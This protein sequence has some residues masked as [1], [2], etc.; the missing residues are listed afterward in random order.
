MLPYAAGGGKPNDSPHETRPELDST[1]SDRLRTLRVLIAHDWII[2]WA[3][4]ERC[5]EQMFQLFPQADLVVGLLTPSLRTYN[6]VTRRAT[7]TWL[8]RVPFARRHHRWFLPLEALAFASLD[9][10]AYD[11]VVSSS[12]AFSKM[13][14]VD[15]PARHICY[16]HS[17]PRYLWDLHQVYLRRSGM[18][19][20]LGLLALGG[21]LR[22][23]DHRAG[24][25]VDR[26][27]AN[28]HFVRERIR[29]NYG[30]D[31]H[32]LY[33]PVARKP[34]QGGRC[35]REDFVLSL[36]R[37]VE[38]KR[39]DLAIAAANRLGVRLVVA[40]DGPERRA[41]EKLAGPTVEIV[42]SVSEP[43]AGR[44]LSTCAAFVFCGEEDFGIAP[45]E[46]NAHGAPVVAYRAG[47]LAETMREGVTAEFFEEQ[48]PEAAAQALR[49]AL[50]R[51]WKEPLLI[52]N[53]QRFAPAAFR[54]GLAEVT[55]SV[56]DQ[57]PGVPGSL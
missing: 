30:R 15:A 26:F 38:Y 6:E 12:H 23:A 55:N 44:L 37:L 29:R 50:N 34:V 36:G 21:P 47:G 22:W 9:T 25:R 42:G 11:L 52:E 41:L 4:S 43:Q 18:L 24:M 17:P 7:E 51:G 28:S 57:A 3:G 13:V 54:A 5:V 40:G 39:I 16:C 35:A 33:P 46:A 14:R 20:R 53:A 8:S 45:I 49:R 48:T 19:K 56:L 27:V 32:V 10:S 1:V 31:A 2:S